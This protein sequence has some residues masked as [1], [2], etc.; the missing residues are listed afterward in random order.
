MLFVAHSRIGNVAVGEGRWG[1]DVEGALLEFSDC[2]LPSDD[3][4]FWTASDA[5]LLSKWCRWSEL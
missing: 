5:D 4:N 3:L 1:V 2:D